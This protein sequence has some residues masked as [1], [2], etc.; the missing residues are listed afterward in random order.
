MLALFG[1]LSQAPPVGTVSLEPTKERL[2]M[3]AR[4]IGY[5]ATTGLLTLAMTGSAV[6]MELAHAPRMVQTLAHLGY[7][8]YLPT[9]LGTWKLLAVAALLAPRAARLKEWAYAG[10]MLDF[11]GA[12]FS[13]LSLGDGVDRLAPPLVLL[14]LAAASWALRPASRTLLAPRPEARAAAGEPIGEAVA[15]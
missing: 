9:L 12:L 4:T 3:N 13:H 15:A 8:E 2:T 11:T 7:P 5:W 14:G 6:F 10:I 1:A